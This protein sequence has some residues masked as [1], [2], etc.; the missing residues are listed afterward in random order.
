MFVSLEEC[1]HAQEV[2]IEE[3]PLYIDLPEYEYLCTCKADLG[4]SC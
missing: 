3:G 4:E 1:I 2:K